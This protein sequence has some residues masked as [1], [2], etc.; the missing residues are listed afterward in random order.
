MP[1]RCVLKTWPLFLAMCLVALADDPS[2]K[3]KPVDRWDK[4]ESKQ[5]LTDSPWVKNVELQWVRDLSPDERREGGNMEASVGRGVGIAGTGLLGPRRQAEAIARAHEKPDPGKVVV[6]WESARPVRGAE[7]KL[8]DTEAPELE[9]DYYAIAVYNMPTPK[10]W[11]LANELKGIATLKRD[12]KK[13]LKPSRVL[14]LRKD[15]GLA[16][17]VYFFKR[18]EIARR[19]GYVL[20]EAQ[21]GRLFV[22]QAFTLQDMQIQG[23][24][25]L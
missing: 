11:N 24:L 13:D 18:V 9:G 16:T 5:V 10:R 23:Q 22:G 14:I 7:Q 12:G 6:R 4:D 3:N 19:D 25:E 2:W 20:F 8:G 1:M 17:L 15:D 21:I